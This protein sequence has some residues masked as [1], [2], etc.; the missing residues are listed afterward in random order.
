MKTFE[1]ISENSQKWLK[2]KTF[3]FNIKYIIFRQFMQRKHE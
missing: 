3:S 2:L 1:T